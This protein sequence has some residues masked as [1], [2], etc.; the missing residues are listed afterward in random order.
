[1]QPENSN[2]INKHVLELSNYRADYRVIHGFL[3][4][5]KDKVPA[6]QR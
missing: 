1:M 6:S 4:R 5:A 3:N 2:Y